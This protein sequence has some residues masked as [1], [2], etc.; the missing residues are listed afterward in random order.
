MQADVVSGKQQFQPA[1]QVI[2]NV[3]KQLAAAYPQFSGKRKFEMSQMITHLAEIRAA[4]P[5]FSA[6][7]RKQVA[8]SWAQWYAPVQLASVTPSDS[9]PL[10]RRVLEKEKN[11]DDAW[12]K[13]PEAAQWEKN[14][15]A[16]LSRMEANRHAT[17]IY[18][19]DPDH[20][21]LRQVPSK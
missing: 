14:R 10:M 21:E 8:G 19:T 3:S 5:R 4:W 9:D 1:P 15:Y 17:M 16:A 11:E 2:A 6:E 20:Y 7:D 18:M 12:K 13:T